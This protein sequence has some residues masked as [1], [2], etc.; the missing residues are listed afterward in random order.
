MCRC[1]QT[2]TEQRPAEERMREGP[3]H[4]VIDPEGTLHDLGQA[5]FLPVSVSSFVKG[6]R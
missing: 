3:T 6:T 2:Q 1:M 4:Q 5:A